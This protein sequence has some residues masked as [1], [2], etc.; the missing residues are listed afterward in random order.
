M[1]LNIDRACKGA[2]SSVA[3]AALVQ[4][5]CAE[6]QLRSNVTQQ[7]LAEA[8]ANGPSRFWQAN[9]VRPTA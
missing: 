5:G 2:Q 6:S 7:Y 9:V 4:L 1:S 8:S 3:D